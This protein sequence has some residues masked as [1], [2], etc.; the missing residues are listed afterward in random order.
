M[1]A[2]L[3]AGRIAL[4]LMLALPV[5]ALAQTESEPKAPVS[6]PADSAPSAPSAQTFIVVPG[7]G[8]AQWTLDGKFSDYV[9][10]MGETIVSDV[11]VTLT[12][13]QFRPQ[14][15]EK[16]YAQTPRIFIVYPPIS[17]DVWAVGTDDPGAQT[18][19]HVGIGSTEDQITAAYQSPQ[20]V[21][22]L[23]Q[24][25]KTLIYDGRGIAFE[26]DY[27]P[28]TGQYAP[29]AGRLFVFRPG[30]ARAIWRLP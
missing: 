27:V 2:L 28:A 17:N 5:A 9:W 24:H 29:H 19:D 22:E 20:F 25:S 26:F 18:I 1:R 8:V 7:L 30:T 14:F 15:E 21:Q 3:H 13:P 11:R 12:D 10:V 4:I 6:D 16:S 23:P